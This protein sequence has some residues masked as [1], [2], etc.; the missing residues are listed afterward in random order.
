MDIHSDSLLKDRSNIFMSD[1]EKNDIRDVIIGVPTLYF[2]GEYIE[3]FHCQ[4][5]LNFR[6]L[7]YKLY[8]NHGNELSWTYR[9]GQVNC[10]KSSVINELLGKTVCPASQTPSLHRPVKLQY[11]SIPF[12]RLLNK[13]SKEVSS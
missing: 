12:V 10:G 13:A 11:G 6:L 1:V 2:V 3:S 8:R 9:P 7:I 4:L 5:L